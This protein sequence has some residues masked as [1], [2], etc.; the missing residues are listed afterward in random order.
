M[1]LL[2]TNF[3]QILPN[4]LI[5]IASTI[6]ALF[7]ITFIITLIIFK[8]AFGRGKGS[9]AEDNELYKDYIAEMKEGGEYFLSLNPEHIYI[10]SFDNLKLHAL[11]YEHPNSKG[12]IILMHGYH[13]EGICDFGPVFKP[14][15]EKGYSILLPDQRAHG[16][17]EGKYLTFGIFESEDC[18]AW[19]RLIAQKFPNRPISLH[20]VSMGGATVCMTSNLQ[21]PSEVKL[22]VDDCGYTSPY[23]IISSVRKSMKLPRFPFQLYVGILTKVFAKFSL[24]QKD[25]TVCVSECKLPQLFIH[26]GSDRLIP[27][28]MGKQIYNSSSAIDKR[29]AIEESADHALAY[30]KNKEKIS[31]DIDYFYDKYMV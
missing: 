21:L 15:I 16:K 11:F 29:I 30:M 2:L 26:G 20:G 8:N 23:A 5:I 6:V 19:A 18:L 3:L 13:G 1:N 17:S 31:V 9:M 7:L 25:S 22:I 12:T 10:N 28:E 24:K 4:I 27:V 14:F